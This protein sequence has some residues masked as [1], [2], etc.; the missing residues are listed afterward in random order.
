MH[1]SF[2]IVYFINRS[3]RAMIEHQRS[4]K[5]LIVLSNTIIG[6]IQCVTLNFNLLMYLMEKVTG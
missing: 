1:D 3:I 2:Q 6:D 4:D 5:K